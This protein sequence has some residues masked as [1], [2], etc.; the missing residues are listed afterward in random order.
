MNDD[1]SKIISKKNTAYSI[2]NFINSTLHGTFWYLFIQIAGALL[3]GKDS[4]FSEPQQ[5][6]ITIIVG[7]FFYIPY[8]VYPLIITVIAI[9]LLILKRK[10]IPPSFISSAYIIYALS[11]IYAGYFLKIGVDVSNYF[12]FI[13]IAAFSCLAGY[14]YSTY[15]PLN[16]DDK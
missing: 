10:I 12:I 9:S 6:V 3:L 1:Q 13:K 16:R 15:N 7:P 5:I 14:I 11:S 8:L 2:K 4:T